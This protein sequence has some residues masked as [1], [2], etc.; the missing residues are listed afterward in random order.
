MRSNVHD[1]LLSIS[2]GRTQARG[3]DGWGERLGAVRAA[4]APS[5]GPTAK[6]G[7]ASQTGG[8]L[9]LFFLFFFFSSA[10]LTFLSFQIPTY[11]GW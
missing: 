8:T 7:R 10:F 2:D 11:R 6:G 3:S 1:T 9:V 4:W 5:V